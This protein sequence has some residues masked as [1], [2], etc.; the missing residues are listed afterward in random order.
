MGVGGFE[1]NHEGERKMRRKRKMSWVRSQESPALRAGQ[2]ELRAVQMK[3]SNT[4]G[5]LIGKQH[6]GEAQLLC[7][8]G[9]IVN[10]KVMGVFFFPGTK[11]PKM[12]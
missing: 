10:I 2:L 11:W 4:S 8:L 5:L 1:E 9:I 6:R 3:Y 7:C 12:G